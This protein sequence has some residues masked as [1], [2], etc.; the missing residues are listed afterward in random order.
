MRVC[1]CTLAKLENR[2]IRQ[3]V[4]H[5]EKYGVD[6]I[7][8]YDNNDIDGEHIEEVINDYI[9]QGFVEIMNWRGEYEAIRR[10]MNDCYN[11]NYMNYD[12]LIF[13]EIDEYIFL[14]D[15]KN[16][17]LFLNQKKFNKCQEIYLNLVCHTDNN[18]LHYEDKPLAERF[19][20][21]VP[22][23]MIGGQ[24]LEMK[25]IIRGHIKGTKIMSLHLGDSRL[26]SC[27]NSG[28]PE[29]KSIFTYNSDQKYYYIDH[30]Y[31]KSTEEFI[32]KIT[33]GDAFSNTLGYFR[34]R[35][36]KYFQQNEITKEKIDMIERET[37]INLDSYR[38]TLKK[39][40]LKP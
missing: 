35:I 3:F 29:K 1:V 36:D 11:K 8:L 18:L 13:F 9:K 27:N 33:K 15:F 4:Q 32:T 25:T 22:K 23:T 10:I 19:P 26:K 7:F 21:T 34:H 12:W 24:K 38:K 6:K 5:Y 39:F 30:Y 14:H 20:F 28:L 40:N 31:S 37:H 17:K 16:V 2:Y